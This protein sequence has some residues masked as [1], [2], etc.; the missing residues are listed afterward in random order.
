M[1]ALF[2]L[3]LFIK[4]SPK[5]S[6]SVYSPPKDFGEGAAEGFRPFSISWWVFTF[7]LVCKDRFEFALF[8]R[9]R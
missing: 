6:L 9:R 8:S 2:S 3:S 1:Q 4:F 5:N 7:D